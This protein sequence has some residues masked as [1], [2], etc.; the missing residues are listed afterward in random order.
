MSK[1]ANV[2]TFKEF[3]P[4]TKNVSYYLKYNEGLIPIQL[5]VPLS[6]ITVDNLNKIG[7]ELKELWTD[8]PSDKKEYAITLPLTQKV[9]VT[10]KVT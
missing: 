6:T 3:Y 1:Y 10:F 9:K 4:K 5:E 7:Q 8:K 2:L